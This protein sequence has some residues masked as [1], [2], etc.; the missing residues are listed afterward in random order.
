MEWWPR[1]GDPGL[2]NR[3]ALQRS[4]AHRYPVFMP[5]VFVENGYRVSFYSYDL[6][7]RIHVHVFKAGHECKMWLDDL[8]VAFNFGFRSHEIAEIRRLVTARRAEIVQRWLEH[9]RGES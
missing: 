5:T 8:S 7:E 1:D 3:F 2:I 6:S 4:D 9:G